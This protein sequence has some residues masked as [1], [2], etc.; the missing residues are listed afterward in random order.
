MNAAD[1][2]Q[3]S[4]LHVAAKQADVINTQALLDTGANVNQQDLNGQTPLHL[5]AAGDHCCGVVS[6]KL[7]IRI[8]LPLGDYSIT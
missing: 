6:V 8:K 5:T 4:A 3:Q 7:R 1:W 2:R